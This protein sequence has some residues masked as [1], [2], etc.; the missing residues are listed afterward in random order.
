MLAK[1]ISFIKTRLFKF[2][3]IPSVFTTTSCLKKVLDSTFNSVKCAEGYSEIPVDEGNNCEIEVEYIKGLLV[4]CSSF[5]S[6]EE[7]EELET[8]LAE[9]ECISN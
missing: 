7:K 6:A 3:L 5:L 1:S 2:A 8:K 9:S 4:N